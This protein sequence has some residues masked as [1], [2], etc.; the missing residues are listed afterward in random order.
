[1]KSMSFLTLNSNPEGH[2]GICRPEFFGISLRENIYAMPD[3][4]NGKKE[5]EVHGNK[6]NRKYSVI[7]SLLSTEPGDLF[8]IYE[9]GKREVYGVYQI[10]S[11]PFEDRKRKIYN[12]KKI[13]PYRF[14][15]RKIIELDKPIN[16]LELIPSMDK[17]KLWNFKNPSF[18][19][20][21]MTRKSLS[22]LTLEETEVL[23]DLLKNKNNIGKINLED[24]EEE[25]IPS[26][27][28]K[29]SLK[30]TKRNKKQLRVEYVLY[31]EIVKQLKDPSSE[32]SE[33]VG[34]W[35]TV[36]PE[37]PISHSHSHEIDVMCI[38]KNGLLASIFN[39]KQYLL[40]ECKTGKLKIDD[41]KSQV[42]PYIN[43]ISNTR[44][45]CKNVKAIMVGNK[46]SD[47]LLD[48]KSKTRGLEIVIYSFSDSS[49]NFELK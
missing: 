11:E 36:I 40:I 8:F 44:K 9:R 35:D 1:M 31:A 30:Y 10:T 22:P 47:K 27:A 46:A 5:G 15:F 33:I 7:A 25:D 28:S 32:F 4:T 42:F 34:S 39:K 2:I 12:Q 41:Y 24:S 13:W 49:L 23:L 37:A 38:K 29:L 6:L 48:K 21:T 19:G 45:N 26:G 20:P 3:P 17:Q 14:K 43:L 18:L 16:F